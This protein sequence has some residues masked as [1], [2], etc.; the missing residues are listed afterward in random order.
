MY[1]FKDNDNGVGISS[2][3]NVIGD[4]TWITKEEYDELLAISIAKEAEKEEAKK[5]LFVNYTE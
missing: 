1:Y 2:N 4:I 5:A 3:Q